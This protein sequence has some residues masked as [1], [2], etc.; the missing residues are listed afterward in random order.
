ML[1]KGANCAILD[2]LSL[3]EGLEVCSFDRIYSNRQLYRQLCKFAIDNVERRHRERSRSG[4]I[5]TM[6]YLGENKVMEFLRDHGLRMA[7]GWIKDPHQS[8]G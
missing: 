6:V 4:T 3:G 5:Q 7:L 2:A 8:E 1:G